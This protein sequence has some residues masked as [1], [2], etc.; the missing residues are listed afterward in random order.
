MISASSDGGII[1]LEDVDADEAGRGMRAT[2]A[3]SAVKA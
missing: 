3:Q 2:A 1:R